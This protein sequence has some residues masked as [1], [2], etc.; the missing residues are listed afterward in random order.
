[1]STNFT[2]RF[3]SVFVHFTSGF[4]PSSE[5][6][7]SNRTTYAICE[8]CHLRFHLLPSPITTETCGE[9][10]VSSLEKKK[11]LVLEI[12]VVLSF[13]TR[14]GTYFWETS[15]G[16]RIRCVCR[17]DVKCSILVDQFPDTKIAEK[18]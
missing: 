6:K 5:D 13:H 16:L 2:G 18:A 3:V 8:T 10:S 4:N 1:M 15:W 7:D 9:R 11:T 17:L 12:T 14:T